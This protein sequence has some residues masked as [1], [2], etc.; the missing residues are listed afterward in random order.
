MDRLP[1]ISQCP[2]NCLCSQD[3]KV[4][5]KVGIALLPLIIVNPCLSFLE[6][7]TAFAVHVATDWVH[8][9]TSYYQLV[10]IVG[11][12]STCITMCLSS[13]FFLFFCR[14]MY[15]KADSHCKG[16]QKSSWFW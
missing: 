16:N 8:S 12:R 10:Y 15:E 11:F 4:S 1:G 3:I 5:Y 9:S 6:L 7:S 14:S 2:E 13:N